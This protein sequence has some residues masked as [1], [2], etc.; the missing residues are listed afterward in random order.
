MAKPIRQDLYCYK[1]QT[2]SQNIYFTY[3]ATK[4]I[5]PLTGITAEAEV[6]PSPNSTTLTATLTC[7]VYANEGRIN[8]AM[9]ATTTAG[10]NP[11]TYAWDLKATNADQEVEYYLCGKFIVDGRVTE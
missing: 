6:R 9:D 10:L 3:R 1:G 8:L 7:S 5:K 4:T 2:Y 11:G